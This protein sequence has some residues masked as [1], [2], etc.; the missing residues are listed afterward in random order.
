MKRLRPANQK[1]T[2]PH[3]IPDTTTQ[4]PAT[5]ATASATN[6][7]AQTST[8]ST[9][10]ASSGLVVSRRSILGLASAGAAA[11]AFAGLAPRAAAGS[12]LGDSLGS[13]VSSVLSAALHRDRP[14]LT[15]GVA[16]GDVRADGAL[17]WTRA[18][19]PSRMFVEASPDPTFL[20]PCLTR[21][22]RGQDILT[23]ASDGTGRLRL[24]GLE[25]GQRYHYRVRVEDAETGIASA[26]LLGS[27]VT[28]PTCAQNIRLHWS[29]DVVGQG[30]GI[31]PDTDG[32]RSFATMADRCPDLFIHSGDTCY[33]D[34][35]VEESVTL[36]DGRIFRNLV[37]E[38]KHKVAETLDEF[39]GQYAY[40]LSDENYRRFNSTVAQIVQ[41]DDHEVTN[42]WYPGE[43]LTDDKYQV[44]DVNL[45]AQRGYQ[46]FHE[47][48][49]IDEKTAVDSRVFR[50]ISY[51][52]LLD[53]FILDMRSYK[54]S[55]VVNHPGTSAPGRILGEEQ[56]R[57]LIREVNASTATWKIIANDLPLGIVVPDATT[58][59]QEGVS[60]GAGGPAVGREAE[61]GR[62]L[63]GIK[64]VANVVWL[65]ADVHY[66]AAHHYSPERAQ[67]QDF[68][69]F[70]EFV[71]G[72]L[73]AGAFGPND[74]DSTFGPEVVY[75]HAPPK[76]QQNSSPLDDY[77]HFGEV[78]ID[79]ESRAL[80]VRLFTSRGK[81]LWSTTLQAT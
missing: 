61:I 10:R 81:Q 70:W 50:K 45:L 29:G 14:V 37:T 47:W 65:T 36:D 71:S 69:P 52:P 48:Q 30:W 32:L 25:P 66:T 60:N 24:V 44:K 6:A 55:N 41:W 16:A 21:T 43:L 75:V 72:P 39:R 53:I 78:D 26:P 2:N 28:A 79:G 76:D 73:H 3:P 11:T 22:F 13:S 59:H 18:D 62:V 49:P 20:N 77:Q 54:D 33:A 17:I 38:H 57:W 35:P 12:L 40:N 67:F 64:N 23:E 8:V 19:R 1:P 5:T 27:F 58:G 63:S 74:M 56:T 4:L 15:H 9:A 31:S 68:A 46:A 80:T 34:G 7:G 51:G 42:N